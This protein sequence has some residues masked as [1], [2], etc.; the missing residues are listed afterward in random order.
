MPTFQQ[1]NLLSTGGC[2]RIYEDPTYTLLLG[3]A[4]DPVALLRRA[5]SHLYEYLLLDIYY[6][7]NNIF[8]ARA[9]ILDIETSTIG[10]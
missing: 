5:L 7:L 8:S 9:N 1:K 6:A 10:R 3:P 4:P 2:L